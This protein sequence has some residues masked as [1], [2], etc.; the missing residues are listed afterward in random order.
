MRLVTGGVVGV[1]VWAALSPLLP[2][3][4]VPARFLLVWLLFTLG[5]GVAAGAW[6]TRDLDAL[7]R[8][9]VLLGIGSAATAVLVDLLGHVG[10][11]AAYPV[12]ALGLAGAS[13]AVWGRGSVARGPR[14][15]WADAAVCL[16]LV[17][18]AAGIG[19]IVF[20][21]RL[22]AVPDGTL[23]NGNYDSFDLSF[24]ASIAAEA[25]HTVPPTA[26]YYA[27]HQ[28]NAAYYPQLVLA[29]VHRFAAVPLLS[30]YLR[31]SWPAF[32]AL[33]ALTAF[34]LVRS[35]A[36]RGV[37]FLAVVFVLVGGDFSYLAAWF[38]PHATI[39]WDY[40]LWPTNFLSPTM[41]VLQFNTWT[42]SLPIFFTALYAVVRAGRTRA[43]GWT[44]IA[45]LLLAV[46]FEF[47]PFAYI[48]LMAG[49]CGAA[50][51]SRADTAGRWRLAATVGFGVLFTLPSVYAIA[52]LPAQDQRSRLLFDF[53]MLPRRMLI[54]TDLTDAFASLANRLAPLASLRTPVFLLL[55]TVLFFL[56]GLGVR[57]LGVRGVGRAIRG[58]ASPDA[59]AWRVL[60]WTVVAGVTIPC[61]LVTDPYVD[62][63][64]FYETG[65]YI[66]WIFTALALVGFARTRRRAGVVAI[67]LALAA[68]LPS[69]IHFLAMKW[70]DNQRPPLT[71]ITRAEMSIAD[72]LRTCDPNTTVVLQDRPFAPSLMA[73]VSERRV[74]LGWGRTYYAVGSESRFRDVESFYMSAR[75]DPGAAFETLRRYHVTHVIV[76]EQRDRVHPDVLARLRPILG[77][78]GF[79]LYAVPSPAGP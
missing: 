40:L 14:I 50:L 45:A 71:S 38:L 19:A 49:L 59:P 66:L 78:S 61:V 13:L 4:P 35:I 70:T 44:V 64:Q 46:L 55:A 2:F 1:C 73:V 77:R 68:S 67:G 37:A 17:A 27:G 11:L 25:S 9:V 26:S 3:V 75:G 63:L 60:G 36:T 34:V 47:K 58:D 33:G 48:V 41:E 8:T 32:L 39:Q 15:S 76:N 6:L 28:L 16:A 65:L 57:W 29:M 52:T 12:L 10:L 74:V 5:P 62:T 43:R 21:H 72:Y 51:F 20:W 53:L 56:V 30:I 24:Y 42:P 69:S 7:T 79:T 22:V 23:L 18:L 31:Y 54:K